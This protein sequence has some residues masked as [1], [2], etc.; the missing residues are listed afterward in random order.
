MNYSSIVNHYE[1]FGKASTQHLHAAERKYMVV[2]Q[3]LV[4]GRPRNV[5][6]HHPG[7]IST[8]IRVDHL[9]GMKSADLAARLDLKSKAAPEL[10]VICKQG[11]D[12]LYRDWSAAGRSAKKHLAHSAGAKAPGQLVNPDPPRIIFLEGIHR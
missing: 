11:V 5:G 3:D 9:R 4:Q 7:P 12:N 10:G 8:R 2:S 6:C 1:C